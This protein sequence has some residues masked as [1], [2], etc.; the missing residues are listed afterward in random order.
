MPKLHA[1]GSWPPCTRGRGHPAPGTRAGPGWGSLAGARDPAW[2]ESAVSSGW[3]AG[4][5]GGGVAPGSTRVL[6]RALAVGGPRGHGILRNSLVGTRALGAEIGGNS[7]LYVWWKAKEALLACLSWRDREWRGSPGRGPGPPAVSG[8]L[9]QVDA[10]PPSARSAPASR[11]GWRRARGQRVLAFVPRGHVAAG[12]VPLRLPS[13]QAPT[14]PGTLAAAMRCS[15]PWWRVSRS[16]W[17]R[18]R[19]RLPWLLLLKNGD[20][21]AAPRLSLAAC[22]SG[23]TKVTQS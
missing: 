20:S 15:A 10:A 14:S 1:G 8:L 13:G 7:H 18:A 17:R 21:S 23:S 9:V 5:L 6:S 4:G 19:L 11:D 12:Q 2:D 3:V 16:S 22:S